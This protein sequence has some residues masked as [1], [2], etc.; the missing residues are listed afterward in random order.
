MNPHSPLFPDND[1]MPSVAGAAPSPPP[2]PG[3]P[4]LRYAQRQQG[5]MRFASLDQLLP[6][7]APVRAVWAFVEQRDLSAVLGQIKA[8][9]GVPG[10]DATDPRIL[11]ALWLQATLDGIGSA[12]A[13]ADL[14]EH[15][16]AYQWLCGGVSLNYH[17]LADFRT[18]HAVLMHDWLID[19]A[20]VL[21]DQGLASLQRVAQ[22]GVKVRASAG[23][24]SFHREPTLQRHLA[25]ARAQVETLEQQAD[26]DAGAVSR[27]QQAA[28]E[29]AA[30]ERQ[31]RLEAAVQ[32]H[33]ELHELREEQKRTKGTK[34][35]PAKLRTSSTDPEAR[36]MKMADGGTRP[37]YNVQVATTTAG[38]VIVGVAVTNAGSDAGQLQPMVEQLHSAYGQAPTEMLVDNNFATLA[39]IE[40]VAQEYQTKVYA[41]VK[42][43]A[44]KRARGDD[45]FAPREKD[46]PAVAAWRE[47]MG[48]AAAQALYRLRAQTAEWA[49]AGFRNHGLQ[50]V[51]VRGLQKVLA[52]VLWQALAHN[53]LRGL[54]L[55]AAATAGTVRAAGGEPV[56]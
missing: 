25:E 10:R 29:R 19:S 20:A 4:R 24:S 55:Q 26:E 47:R 15:H 43:E 17:T 14:C 2:V 51:R 39:D 34:Y 32:Q 3:R 45:P 50:Q 48:T 30:R 37:A 7:D 42:D 6:P 9:E 22:D 38:G 23:S 8:V 52:V 41:P 36:Q 5:E 28:H 44:K 49:N 54:A 11:M 12:R 31:Q 40:A 53:L 56:K 33:A 35:D 16:L 18:A 27:R 1:P 46:T 13:L 21:L